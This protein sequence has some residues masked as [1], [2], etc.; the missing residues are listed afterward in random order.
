MYMYPFGS[1]GCYNFGFLMN[2]NGISG[3][4]GGRRCCWNINNSDETNQRKQTNRANRKPNK[5]DRVS[6]KQ[7]TGEAKI[8]FYNLFFWLSQ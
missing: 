6:Q 5:R 3:G 1:G 7:F 8:Y 2:V 4:C